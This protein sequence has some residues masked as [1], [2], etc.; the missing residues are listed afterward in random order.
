MS[1]DPVS[2]DHRLQGILAAY[3][4]DVEAGKN[5]DREKLLAQHPDLADDLRS[6]LAENDK[7]RRLVAQNEAETWGP[8]PLAD[9]PAIGTKVRY[10]GDYELLEE[11]ARGGMGV[12]YQARQVSLNR[13]VA[14][15]MILKGELAMPADVQRF[16]DEATAAANLDHA[17][18]VPIYEIGEHEGQQYFS[19]KLIGPGSRRANLGI[20]ETVRVVALAARAVHHAHQ[21]GILH[22]DLKPGNILFDEHGEPCVGD[23]GLAKRIESDASTTKSGMIVGTPA[24]MAPE[25]ARAE[26]GLTTAVDVYSLGAVLYEWLTGRPPFRGADVMSTMMM[27]MT[28]APTRPRSLNRKIDRDLETICL[29][30][31]DKDP[32]KRYGSAE[33]LA[34]D[35]DRWQQGKPIL[36]RRIGRVQRLWR[37]CRRKPAMAAVT[38]VALVST[39]SALALFV[40]GIIDQNEA[41]CESTLHTVELFRKEGRIDDARFWLRQSRDLYWFG[42]EV[43]CIG[44][45]LL[46]AATAEVRS[47]RQVRIADSP[48]DELAFLDNVELTWE[49]ADQVRIRIGKD[50]RICTVSSGELVAQKLGEMPPRMPK[51]SEASP[52]VLKSLPKDAMLLGRS[53]NDAWAVLRLKAK[54][55]GKEQIVLWDVGKQTERHVLPEVGQVPDFV[56]VSPD[57]R[58]MAYAD[59]FAPPQALRLWN[60]EW[61]QFSLL[62]SGIAQHR[63]DK[64]ASAGGFSPDGEML[65]TRG[66]Q[67][68]R[69]DLSVWQVESGRLLTRVPDVYGGCQWSPDSRR[70]AFVRQEM[71]PGKGEPGIYLQLW[72]VRYPSR[73]YALMARTV[74]NAFNVGAPEF[75]PSTPFLAWGGQFWEIGSRGED[76]VLERA[77]GFK[78]GR[79]LASVADQLHLKITDAEKGG[80]LAWVRFAPDGSRWLIR[81]PIVGDAAAGQTVQ[82]ERIGSDPLKRS[83]VLPGSKAP[84]GGKGEG[85]QVSHIAMSQDGI[86]ALLSTRRVEF[87]PPADPVYGNEYLLEWWDLAEGK[88]LAV[89]NEGAPEKDLLQI[90][91]VADGRFA[92]TLCRSESSKLWDIASGTIKE[93]L[94]SQFDKVRTC[95]HCLSPDHRHLCRFIITREEIDRKHVAKRKPTVVDIHEI[96]TGQLVQHLTL[97]DAYGGWDASPVAFHLETGWLAAKSGAYME[98]WNLKTGEL[99]ARWL[100]ESGFVA[101]SHDGQILATTSGNMLRLWP[102]PYLKQ[103]VEKLER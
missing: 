31:L 86:H 7:M 10:F 63:D 43:I 96:A 61:N 6:F 80:D 95:G 14:V 27:V 97:K 24:Y 88:R 92:L 16:R 65:I 28:D 46:I 18:I 84:P 71:F 51:L 62:D 78:G 25:Q 12:V 100:H 66:K 8:E 60:W 87:N 76:K 33:A 77:G 45:A 85:R 15:K 3:L 72:E 11:I 54:E 81:Y 29:K 1:S 5:P 55:S 67:D 30:C 83:L 39:F 93:T 37:W 49:D 98:L 73:S 101:I 20:P 59:P 47:L 34:D 38:L 41:R 75:S 48:Q 42:G 56:L 17:N 44:A 53:A 13:T 35:L 82:A 22:R 69:I 40:I 23:F 70:L 74:N 99:W 68:G 89:W 26:K 52:K 21:R 50:V 90:T 79:P 4:Q 94:P 36:A 19:M 9:A 2:R 58:H 91:L 102:L 64:L 32:A 103:E 57:G